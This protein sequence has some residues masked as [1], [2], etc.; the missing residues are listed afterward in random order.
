LRAIL[1][2]LERDTFMASWRS[3]SNG[4]HIKIDQ[5][6]DADLLEIV[7]GIRAF[8]AEVSLVLLNSA[9]GYPTALCLA[10]GDGNNWPGVSLGLGT[11][12]DPGAAVRQAILELG[13]TGPYLRRLMKTNGYP[14]PASSQDVRQMLDHASYYFPRERAT[15]FDYLRDSS[16]AC[17]LSDVAKGEVERSLPVCTAALK[18]AG[19]RVAL[20]DVTSPDIRSTPFKVVRAVSPDLQPISFGYG[21]DRETVPRLAGSQVVLAAHEISPIW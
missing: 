12:P 4:Q 21:L 18:S 1:E 7:S 13:Q 14:V 9:C 6:L 17:S 15:A 16:N 5:A 19:I 11:D 8:G 20:V 3:K 10:F 2:L